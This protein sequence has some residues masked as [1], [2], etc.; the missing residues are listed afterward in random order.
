MHNYQSEKENIIGFLIELSNNNNREWFQDSKE[1]FD[2]AKD[3]FEKVILA[4]SESIRSFDSSLN[5]EFVKNYVFRI[6]RDVRF[7][8]DKTPYKNHFGAYIANGG[9]KSKAPGYYIH[10]QPEGVFVGGGVYGPDK[11][12]LKAI[13]NE[14]YYNYEEF[15]S[16]VNKKNFKTIFGE[17]GGSKLKTGP[18]DFPKDHESIEFLKHKDFVAVRNFSNDEFM[19]EGF[20]EEVLKVFKAQKPLNDFLAR[21]IS[22]KEDQ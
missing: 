12:N 20:L 21:A 2:D 8:K 6:Y 16:I 19:K 10:I 11:E 4:L 15:C 22:M 18:K 3:D 13:R 14:I 5:V 1:E 17:L 7:S 9:K